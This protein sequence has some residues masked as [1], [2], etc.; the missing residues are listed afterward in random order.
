MTK[1]ARMIITVISLVL[2][3]P[4]G[5][6]DLKPKGGAGL[7]CDA[8][9]LIRRFV[10]LFKE[11]PRTVGDAQKT[12]DAVNVEGKENGACI[13]SWAITIGEPQDV[14]SFRL[15]METYR[16]K[17]VLMT[18]LKTGEGWKKFD[19]PAIEYIFVVGPH[20]ESI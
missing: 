3:A 7:I 1:L 18:G 9:Q 13:F 15:G 16:I 17:K 20:E 6:E 19:P 14:E 4:A 10:E 11:T 2:V 12:I 8:P 5:A